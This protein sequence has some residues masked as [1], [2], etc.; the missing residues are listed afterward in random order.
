MLKDNS[1]DKREIKKSHKKLNK[2]MYWIFHQ[3]VIFNSQMK[4]LNMRINMKI[5]S[6]INY[7]NQ[8]KK[9]FMMVWML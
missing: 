5:K 8:I 9:Y 6:I 2:N 3:E 1:K 7:K 4:T